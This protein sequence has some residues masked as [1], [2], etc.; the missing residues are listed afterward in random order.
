MEDLFKVPF[1]AKE[2]GKENALFYEQLFKKLRKLYEL[3]ELLSKASL[4][5][6]T[7]VGHKPHYHTSVGDTIAITLNEDE[8]GQFKELTEEFIKMHESLKSQ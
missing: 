4:V 7:I 3:Q 8:I 1:S 6:L 5:Q 2:K